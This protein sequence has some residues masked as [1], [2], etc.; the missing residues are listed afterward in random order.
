MIVV[1]SFCGV[2]II[3]NPF[4][5]MMAEGGFNWYL[6]MPVG[7][8]VATCM[9][10]L[11]LHEMR[12]KFKE[13]QILEYTYSLQMLIGGLMVSAF[14]TTHSSS[15][16]PDDPLSYLS[17]ALY[18]S[19][20]IVFAYGSNFL[21]IKALFKRKPSEVMVFNYT[22]IIYSILIDVVV[23]KNHL[24]FY[25]NLGVL[26]TSAGLLSQVLIDYFQKKG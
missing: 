15:S 6:L 16:S 11:Y 8:S 20:I 22:G 10:Y 26:M 2:L 12:G 14:G 18:M 25:Q 7:A 3:L 24:D 9:N 13:L 23:F 19:L 1:I 21:R 5:S 17:I 4:S